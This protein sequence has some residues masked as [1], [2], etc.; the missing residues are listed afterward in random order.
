MS[1]ERPLNVATPLTAFTVLVPP[2]VPLPGFVAIS[3]VIEAALVVTMLPN[4]S[5]TITAG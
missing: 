3:R 5:F 2:S 4:V 1:I